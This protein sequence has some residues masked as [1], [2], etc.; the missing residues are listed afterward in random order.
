LPVETLS[1]VAYLLAATF[2]QG[3]PDRKHRRRNSV[4]YISKCYWY[5]VTFTWKVYRW[6]SEIIFLVVK[7]R[8]IIGDYTF[9]A[10]F[11][12]TVSLVIYFVA[13]IV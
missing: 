4:L 5:V 1:P 9:K 2:Y 13:G 6:K 8:F 3:N 11:R 10:L 7:Y 12:L